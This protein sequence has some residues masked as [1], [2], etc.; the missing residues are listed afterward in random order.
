MA[1]GLCLRRTPPAGQPGPRA[2]AAADAAGRVCRPPASDKAIRPG[3]P[4]LPSLRTIRQAAGASPVSRGIEGRPEGGP[5]P[6]RSSSSPVCRPDGRVIAHPALPD[7]GGPGIA[8]KSN[9]AVCS[10]PSRRRPRPG[11]QARTKRTSALM[12]L[13]RRRH[14]PGSAGVGGRHGAVSRTLAPPRF[15]PEQSRPWGRA[16]VKICSHFVPAESTGTKFVNW[17]HR[18]LVAAFQRS[19]RYIPAAE[20]AARTQCGKSHRTHHS[21]PRRPDRSG[22]HVNPGDMIIAPPSISCH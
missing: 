12:R 7:V 3:R 2:A 1:D 13:A 9:G 4:A 22:F 17:L 6:A 8:R 18:L 11:F 5:I 10:D 21:D 20:P 16:D 15:V 14:K 19:C